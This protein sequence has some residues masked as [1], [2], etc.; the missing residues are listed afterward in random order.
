MKRAAFGLRV[1]SGWGALVAVTGKPGAEEV[2][3]RRRIEIIDPKAVGAAQ[4]FHFAKKLELAEAEKHVA[5]CATVSARLALSALCDSV[6]E[7]QAQGYRVAGGAILLSSGRALP[8]FS[9]ILASHALIHTAEGEFFRQAFRSALENL[10]I[11]VSASV[12]ANSRSEPAQSWARRRQASR[13]A[14][15]DSAAH[16]ARPGPA[17]RKTLPWRLSSC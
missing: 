17:T 3:Q 14:L 10:K 13:G 6:E 1:H 12:N 9:Q 4:P 7:L 5:T 15:Q 2:I 11:P 8:P 16:S